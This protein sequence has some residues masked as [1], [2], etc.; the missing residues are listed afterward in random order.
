[1]FDMS[2][3][4]VGIHSRI[5]ESTDENF[6]VA[7]SAFLDASWDR[8]ARGEDWG[9]T[10]PPLRAYFGASGVDHPEGC[11]LERVDTNSPAARAG[12][13][14][15][16]IV[17]KFNDQ[18]IKDSDSFQQSLARVRPGTEVT[19]QIKRDNEEMSVRVTI[20]AR[21]GGRGRGRFGGP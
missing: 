13:K 11:R 7:I 20:G 8:L 21:G 14:V 18:T 10:R 2:G 19:L 17:V 15:G 16:D 6:H 12:L 1:L 9:N 5:S 3:R 4:V